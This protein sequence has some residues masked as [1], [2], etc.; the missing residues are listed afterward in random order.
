MSLP[1]DR[2]IGFRRGRNQ[3]TFR[4]RVEGL[5]Q[6]RLLTTAIGPSGSS[7]GLAVGDLSGDGRPDLIQIG[8]GHNL[9]IELNTGAPRTP[10]G[11]SFAP[12]M[13]DPLDGGGL[14]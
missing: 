13:I 8:P 6:R 9:T 14:R 12:T 3:P 2:V 5:E 4:P 11:G 10:T 1:R 7:G